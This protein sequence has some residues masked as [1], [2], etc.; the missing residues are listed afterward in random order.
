[1][2]RQ[3]RSLSLEFRRDA[4]RLV[5]DQGYS[6]SEADRSLDVG[7]TAMRRW[8]RQLEAEHGGETPAS[9][10]LTRKQQKIRALEA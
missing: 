8:V 3:R 10:A 2:S 1:M 5:V 4:A 7:T 9:K 6:V